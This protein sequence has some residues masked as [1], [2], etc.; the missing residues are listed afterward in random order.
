MTMAVTLRV[1]AVDLGASSGRV[2]VGRG[3]PGRARASSAVAPLPERPGA[4]RRRRCTGTSLGL[5]REVLDGLRERGRGR[6]PLDSIGIDS[7]AVDYGLLDGDG[8]LLGDP[9][10]YRDEPHR[11][12]RASGARRWCRTTSS[13]PRTGLQYLPFNTLYQLAA[14]AAAT[15]DGAATMLLI[16]DL[17]ALLADRRGGAERTN[18]S[19]T[20]LLDV[21]TARLGDRAGRAGSAS[22]RRPAAAA[23]ARRPSSAPLL[24]EVAEATGL[25]RRHAGRRGRLARHRLRGRRRPADRRG[26]RLH[27]LRH[28]VAGRASSSTRRCS[29][30]RRAPPNFTNEGGV[31]GDDPL[32]AQRDGPVAAQRVAAHLGRRGDLGTGAAR[33]RRPPAPA[34]RP[35][36][37]RRRPGVPAA[38]ATCRR[39]SPRPA[40]RP[41]S[42]LRRPAARSVR[43]ILESLAAGLPPR[44]P[45][46]RRAVAAATVDVVHIVGG[47]AR[48][49][50]A[51]P[52]HRRPCGLPGARRTGRGHRAR[53]RAG[54]GPR[55]R[56]RPARTSPR[57][58]RWSAA[59]TTCGATSPADELGAATGHASAACE[60]HELDDAG[61]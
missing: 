58:A 39:G 54:P 1:A 48:N 51:V 22:G 44:R 53:Q 2:M 9:F 13:T 20:G 10:H 15:L 11:R 40:A 29:P 37:R 46:T 27:L 17:L 49:E 8:A 21:A 52:A 38:R 35:D 41:A 14:D 19:T 3:R 55:P 7:W 47:G 36:R 5:Y 28:L 24:P 42:P 26:V 56:R 45:A 61:T 23:R 30:R 12:R 33:R 18:A 32:P 50:P 4:R 34:G 43:C 25:P 60:A 16:P 31:D 59:P 57:C 6:R